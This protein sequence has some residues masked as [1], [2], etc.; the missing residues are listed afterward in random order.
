[1]IRKGVLFLGLLTVL[2]LPVSAE[3]AL[4]C[5][6]IPAA[7]AGDAQAR[8]DLGLAYRKGLCVDKDTK[9]ALSWLERSAEQGHIP[10]QHALG[11]IFFSGDGLPA[12][13][14]PRAKEWY[15]KAALQG[16][17]PSQLRLAFL[18]AENHFK[19][20]EVDYAEAEKWFIKAAEQ[21]AGDARFRLG[22]FYHH[23]KNPP[24]YARAVEWLT[25]AAEG[26]HRTA[27]FDLATFYR[28][29]KGVAPDL[30]KSLEWLKAAG[31]KGVLP[32]QIMLAEAYAK[33]ENGAN[34]DPAQ[35][36]LWARRV[37]DQGAAPA[38]WL[39]HVADI[40]YDGRDGIPKNYPLAL[41]YYERAARKDDIHALKRATDMHLNGLGAPKDPA[42]AKAYQDQATSR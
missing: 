27:M 16:H 21:D 26:G 32:A 9:S 17:G 19:G 34:R 42:R 41:Q 22:N 14:Y 4:P 10:A 12:P 8:F 15:T 39:N 36:F 24:D 33:G 28:E 35:S 23:Y 7:E 1:M 13:D 5:P 11:D 31:E 29:G 3:N 2:A 30:S 25:R 18:Y 20:L 37:A 38:Y 6:N 40:L